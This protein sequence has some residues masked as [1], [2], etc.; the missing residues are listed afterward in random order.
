VIGTPLAQQVFDVLDAIT[1]D[2]PRLRDF[3]AR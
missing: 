1:A 3:G 2:E